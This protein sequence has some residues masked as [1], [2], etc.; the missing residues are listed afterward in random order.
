MCVSLFFAPLYNHDNDSD[1]C[2][3]SHYPN[4]DWIHAEG[5]L[6]LALDNRLINPCAFSQQKQ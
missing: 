3:Y 1:Y 6:S 4:Y 5:L 2:N